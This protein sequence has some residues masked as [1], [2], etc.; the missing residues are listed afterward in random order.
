MRDIEL[1][2]FTNIVTEDPRRIPIF[3]T[4]ESV[5]R[6]FRLKS[7]SK[8]RVYMHPHP[9]RASA[10][11]YADL[12]QDFMQ[13]KNI[14][15]EIIETDGLWDGYVRSIQAAQA[16]FVLQMEHDWSFVR[17]L[18]KHSAGEIV[19]LMEAEDLPYFRFNKRKNGLIAGMVLKVEEREKNGFSYC[20]DNVI[21]NN[22]HFIRTSFYKNVALPILLRDAGQGSLGIER[23][24]TAEIARGACYGPLG[25]PKTIRHL[26]GKKLFLKSQM[27]LSDRLFYK[28]GQLKRFQ[29]KYLSGWTKKDTPSVADR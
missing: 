18:I 23:E 20:R 2:F 10:P 15:V 3:E 25:Y 9:F 19:S 22:P 13:R 12:L 14:E 7:F 27:N 4:I 28:L 21:S 16:P 8:H 24:L 6:T 17:R 1:N 5:D 29:K 26:N 11:R